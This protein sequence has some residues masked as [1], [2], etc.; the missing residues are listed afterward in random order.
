MLKT[1]NW[2]CGEGGDYSFVNFCVD[3]SMSESDCQNCTIICLL[4]WKLLAVT[5]S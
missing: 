5:T 2:F 4:V 1:I 3:D